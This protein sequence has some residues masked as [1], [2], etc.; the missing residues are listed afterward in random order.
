ME[1]DV[2]PNLGRGW[3]N[4]TILLL[5]WVKVLLWPKN[6]DFLP[7]KKMLASAKRRGSWY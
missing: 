1:D 4:F 3:G 7:K 6:A 2:N 5:L